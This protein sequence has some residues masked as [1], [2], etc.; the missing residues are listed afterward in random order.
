V[1]V[2]L[3]ADWIG[4]GPTLGWS[5]LASMLS[6]PFILAVPEPHKDG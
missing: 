4:L 3:V 5:V 2:G 1:V 6:I